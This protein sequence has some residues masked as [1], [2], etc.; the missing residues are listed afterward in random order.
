METELTLTPTRFN[1][2]AEILLP[3]EIP[4]FT[5]RSYPEIIAQLW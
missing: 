5:S 1:H 2:N 3:Q 4:D